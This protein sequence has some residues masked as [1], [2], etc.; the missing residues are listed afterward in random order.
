MSFEI[1]IDMDANFAIQKYEFILNV[2]CFGPLNKT[3]LVIVNQDRV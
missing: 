2:R 3:L 1:S